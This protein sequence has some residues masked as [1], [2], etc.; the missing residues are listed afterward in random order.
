MATALHQQLK[1][2]YV[3][4][5]SRHEVLI[6]GY[7]I[8]AVDSKNRLI[9]IQCAT[10][11]SIRDKVRRLIETHQVIVVKPLASR[12]LIVKKAKAGGDVI[13]SRSSPLRQSLF[14]VFREL[15]H[16]STVFPHPRLRLDVLLTQQSEVRIPPTARSSWKKRYR[17]EDRALVAV[18]SHIQLKTPDDLWQALD[19]SLAPEFTTR[20]L[21]VGSGMPLWLAQ[22]AAYCFRTMGFFEVCAKQ[23]NSIVYR[24]TARRTRCRRKAG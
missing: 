18:D 20:D 19:V 9:E 8:D 11:S 15:V 4:D 6:D 5:A 22:K 21:A 16:F 7:R 2:Y 17:V 10:L 13:S 12:K 14:Y 24:L 23:S 1:Q 3:P